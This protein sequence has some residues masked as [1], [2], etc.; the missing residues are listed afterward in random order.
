VKPEKIS[1]N[2]NREYLKDNINNPAMNRTRKSD[3]YIEQYMNL[4]GATNFAVTQ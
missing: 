3:T 2:K 4:R 1:R